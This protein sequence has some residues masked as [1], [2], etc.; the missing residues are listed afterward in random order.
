MR[1]VADSK[2]G[3]VVHFYDKISV[4]IIKLSK[5]LKQGDTIKFKRGE[6]EFEQKLASMEIEHKEIKSA[7]KGD[8]VGVKTDQAVRENTEVYKVS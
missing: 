5:G 3:T 8:E 2:V 4:A 6:D 7:K 1:Q